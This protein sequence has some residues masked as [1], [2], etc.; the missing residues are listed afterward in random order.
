MTQAQIIYMAAVTAVGIFVI[1]VA[2]FFITRQERSRITRLKKID[3]FH[4]LQTSFPEDFAERIAKK[5]AR[6]SIGGRYS[7]LRKILFFVLVLIWIVVLVF[8]FLG[9]MPATILSL[10]TAATAVIIGIA[11]RPYVE[12][13]ISG[14][15]ISFSDLLKIGDTVMVDGSYGTV[16]DITLTHTIIKIWDWRRL[17]VPNSVMVQKEFVNY[18]THDSYQWV[19]VEFWVAYGS[20]IELV[21]KAAVGSALESEHIFRDTE[22]EFWVM[23]MARE[24]IK[25]WIAAWAESPSNGWMLRVD[26]RETL[27]KKL[28][29]AGIQTHLYNQR[30]FSGQD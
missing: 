18:D 11:A 17:I 12:N 21:K 26:I 13:I 27:L 22:P 19:Y 14:I 1:L 28:D 6:E 29:E 2:R 5:A 7:I 4:A 30:I 25:C 23:D 3:D 9:D 16:E 15:V 24:G 10:V 20:D 8:P